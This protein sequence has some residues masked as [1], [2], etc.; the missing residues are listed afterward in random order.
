MKKYLVLLLGLFMSFSMMAQ[1]NDSEPEDPEPGSQEAWKSLKDPVVGWGSI[2]VRY[3]RSQVAS[4]QKSLVLHAWKGERVSAQAV[5]ST[6]TAITNMSF[7]VSDLKNG[8]N[9]IS[10]DNVNKYFVRYVIADNLES[11]EAKILQAD[12][13]DNAPSI[14][15]S[16]NTTR[17]I[18]L[19]IHVPATAKAGKYTGKLTVFFDT[20]K[21]ELPFVLEVVDRTLPEPKDWAFHLDLWQNPYAVARYYGNPLW[22]KEHF[23]SMRPIMKMLANAGQKVITCSIIQHPWNGQTYDPFESMIAKMKQLDGSW[24]YDYTVFDKWVQFMMDCGITEQI[25]C[26][27]LVPWHYKFDYYDCSSNSV[28]YI[29]CKPDEKEYRDFVLPF[30]KDFAAHLKQKG[31]FDRTCI[32]MD[33][34]PMD[35]LSAAYKI[36]KEADPGYR[37]QGAANFNVDEGT[38]GDQMYDLSVAF[39]FNLIEGKALERRKANGQRL[40]FYTCCGPGRPNTFTFSDPAE[41]AF[42]GWHSASV[43]YNG[44]LRWAWCSWPAQPNQDS[45][46][47]NWPSGDTYLVYPGQSCIRLE[48]L[49]EGIQYYEKIRILRETANEK[50][51]AKL[52]A[53]LEKFKFIEMPADLKMETLINEGKAVLKTIEK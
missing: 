10:A 9:I 25:D 14:S 44:Y 22:S 29:N 11:R 20:K 34:R 3:P 1:V 43:G 48:R 12:R 15:V 2:D 30:L 28:K 27:S 18:W 7:S 23:D 41:S 5:L 6:P 52:D 36:V 32:A 40:T 24:K 45:R 31:W 8:K 46:F 47:G 53:L 4:F 51:L 17:P 21:Q 39:Q 37:I 50:Q 33:E 26:Y 42:L 19:D 16:A 13:L 49:V 35:Q 38:I